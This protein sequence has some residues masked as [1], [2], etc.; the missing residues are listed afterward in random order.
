[1]TAGSPRSPF[2]ALALG[3]AGWAWILVAAAGCGRQEA[4]SPVPPRADPAQLN[5][6]GQG[7]NIL[8]IM[9]DDLGADQVSAIAEHPQQPNT[10][11]MTALAQSGVLFRN[12][13][14]MSTCTPTRAATLTGRYP[15]RYGLGA[16]I[17]ADTETAQLP[18][19]EVT[20]PEML[21]QGTEHHYST[22][23]I[24]K[25][26][27]SSYRS[28]GLVHHPLDQGFGWFEGSLENLGSS[29]TPGAD[30]SFYHW[31]RDTNGT[32]DIA[33]TYATTETVNA[34]LRQ[35]SRLPEPWF[36]MVSFNAPHDPQHHPPPEL[37]SNP[38]TV[39]C[40]GNTEWICFQESTEA[41]DREIGRLLGSLDPSLIANTT[42]I[43]TSD[44]GPKDTFIRPPF[45]P[46]R[47]KGT[48]FDGALHVPLIVSG[49]LV[50]ERGT[51]SEGL[52]SLVDIFAT[53]ADLA[54]V[55]L[56]TVVGAD[57]LPLVHDSVSF[58]RQ[59]FDPTAPRAAPRDV[60][61]F[62]ELFLRNGA[63]PYTQLERM[64]R[65][66][67]AKLI[68]DDGREE[69]YMYLP[70]AIDEGD[71]AFYR[72]YP[73]W[74]FLDDYQILKGAMDEVVASFPNEGP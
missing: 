14:S 62:A 28:P 3:V 7:G 19:S 27:L 17:D 41:V 61:V 11:V 21:A 26:H 37:V 67:D 70:G 48:M 64:V 12:A 18:L 20:I 54:G 51:V 68:V 73:P 49:P 52:V 1:M 39:P 22:A 65:T 32:I 57:G 9:V 36:V 74:A 42:V 50:A 53:V 15:S 4:P 8:F 59:I 69:L 40:V 5:R 66:A 29:M 24:G 13:Y 23:L 60:Y 47:D 63:P 58:A 2:R 34:T 38:T 72:R 16:R 31:E 30:S 44:N 55:D 46:D 6:E 45:D 35:I 25:W 10:P 33:D 43:L 56:D 71:D